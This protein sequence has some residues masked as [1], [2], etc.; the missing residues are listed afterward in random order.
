MQYKDSIE[1]WLFTELELI[2]FTKKMVPKLKL[3]SY[4]HDCENDWEWTTSY[5]MPKNKI[6]FNVR[7]L[8]GFEIPDSKQPLIINF[9]KKGQFTTKE[10]DNIGK[11]ISG[12][13]K[14][15]VYF[16]E[17]DYLNDYKFGYNISKEYVA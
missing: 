3:A 13:I 16:G 14:N 7:R 8:W 10:I 15:K 4:Y 2:N 11:E 6:D 5:S 12:I 17:V 9:Y 1:F